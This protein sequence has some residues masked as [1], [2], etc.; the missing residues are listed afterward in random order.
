MKRLSNTSLIARVDGAVALLAAGY[1]SS[2]RLRAREV[3]KAD[4]S[5]GGLRVGGYTAEFYNADEN[6]VP[7]NHLSAAAS[8]VL[9]LAV[10]YRLNF[11]A[12]EF[13]VTA[14]KRRG[15]LPDGATE[16]GETNGSCEFGQPEPDCSGIE[17]SV[18]NQGTA[19]E[20]FVIV[21]P[22]SGLYWSADGHWAP[23]AHAERHTRDE[24]ERRPNLSHGGIW[25]SVRDMAVSPLVQARGVTATLISPVAAGESEVG[26]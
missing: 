19:A 6:W 14:P 3:M 5:L 8:E 11:P 18:P 22:E 1:R 15:D 9:D 24:M 20:E 2:I 4:S 26:A 25:A 23:F 16:V 21:H 17:G 7:A 12:Y 13:E 10:H